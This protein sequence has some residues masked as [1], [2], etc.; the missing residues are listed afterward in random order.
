MDEST[1][2]AT[3]DT[4]N[5]YRWDSTNQQYIYKYKS[6]STASGKCQFIRATLDDGTT[7]S[8]YVR[9]K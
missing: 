3:P 9:Y 2:T 7:Q 8:V 6:L 1:S 4:S 5:T